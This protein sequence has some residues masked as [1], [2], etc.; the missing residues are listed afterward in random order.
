MSKVT[1]TELPLTIAK[2]LLAIE[3]V[4]L[5]PN[6]PFTWTSG[7]KSPI[8]CDNRLTMSYPEIRDLIAEGFATLIRELYPD[9]EVIAG[10]STAGIPHAA[11]VAQKL[12]LPMAYIRD[13]AKGHGKQNQIEGRIA[14]GQKV[15]VIED[16]IS[17]GGS[18]LKAALAVREAGAEVQSVLAI[19]TYQFESAVQAFEAES[20][21]LQ[22]L[23]N[24]SALIQ[25]AVEVGKVDETDVDALQAWRNDPHSFGK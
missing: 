12:N 6:D 16:L 8:Y 5:R 7:I 18:S 24:Y 2:S 13:K 10:T 22:T 17:T 11:W 21:P 20:V 3:A 4:A 1:L 15:V 19:F 25:A 9:T 14:P 23:S